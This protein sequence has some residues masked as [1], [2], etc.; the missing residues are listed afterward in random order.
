MQALTAAHESGGVNALIAAGG[1]RRDTT[2][3]NH[4]TLTYTSEL[5]LEVGARDAPGAMP[6][7][8][9]EVMKYKCT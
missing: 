2:W 1:H 3:F 5:C 6:K 7:V 9:F 8:R 4:T